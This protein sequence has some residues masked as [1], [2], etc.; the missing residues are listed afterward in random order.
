MQLVNEWRGV[1]SL[2]DAD[3]VKQAQASRLTRHWIRGAEFMLIMLAR[4]TLK[5]TK[6]KCLLSY[7]RDSVV[8][9][10]GTQERDRWAAL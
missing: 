10:T 9:R 6:M 8:L 5:K 3:V 4:L 1:R 7:F 2:E